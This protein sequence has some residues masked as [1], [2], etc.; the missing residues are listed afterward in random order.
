MAVGGAE[1]SAVV[2]EAD[3]PAA[4]AEEEGFPVV[5][6]VLVAAAPEGVGNR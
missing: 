2:E 3:S 1:D 4:E 5:E 6:G